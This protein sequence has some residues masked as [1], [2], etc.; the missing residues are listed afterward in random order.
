MPKQVPAD[1][2]PPTAETPQDAPS[3]YEAALGELERLV[4]S[5][6]AGALPLDDLLASYRRG[7]YLLDYCREK[8]EAVEQQVQVLEAGQWRSFNPNAA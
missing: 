4:A 7:A 5:M 1:G 6:E 2:P 3:N 8:L